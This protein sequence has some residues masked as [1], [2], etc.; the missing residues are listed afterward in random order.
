MGTWHSR[1]CLFAAA[2]LVSFF[3]A[4]CAAEYFVDSEAGADKNPGT[5]PD[6]PW[7]T[8]AAV[9]R[10][11]FKPGDTLRFKCGGTWTG[12]LILKSSGAEGNPI[13]LT[14]Y[15][16][17]AKPVLRNPPGAK[18]NWEKC[19]DVQ[20]SWVVVDGL[21]LRDTYEFGVQISKDAQHC[22]VRNCEI[23]NV[24]IG[25]G[26]KGA[27]NVVT[28]NSIH[29]LVMVRNTKENPD[30]DYGAVAVGSSPRTTRS[31]STGW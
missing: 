18:P 8:L 20:G 17:G 25:I 15:G 16:A 12:L 7:Q 14:S 24:G 30:D 22:V 27:R 21:L 9:Q 1:R 10:H 23:T 4:A 28:H 13:T 26:V 6:R 11:A 29:D 5:A 2:A 31:P 19:V 3:S